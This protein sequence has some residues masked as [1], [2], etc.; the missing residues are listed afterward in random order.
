MNE[1]ESRLAKGTAKAAGNAISYKNKQCG[2][3]TLSYL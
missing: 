2:Y 1:E 3:E